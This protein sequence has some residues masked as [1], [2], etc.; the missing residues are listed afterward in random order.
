MMIITEEAR[1]KLKELEAAKKAEEAVKKNVQNVES[2]SGSSSPSDGASSKVETRGAVSDEGKSSS[3]QHNGG[4]KASKTQTPLGKVKRRRG[5][6][7]IGA[8]VVEGDAVETS[9]S[10]LDRSEQGHIRHLHLRRW[11]K[12]LSRQNLRTAWRYFRPA[13]V[14]VG[15]RMGAVPRHPKYPLTRP[16]RPRVP[17]HPRSLEQRPFC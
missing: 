14:L 2:S 3:N 4:K 10:V 13:R 12:A 15:G 5:T 17:R 9:H 16:R 6:C 8:Q 1:R 11:R 7:L